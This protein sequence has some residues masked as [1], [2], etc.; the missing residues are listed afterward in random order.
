M[1]LCFEAVCIH[2][3]IGQ[4]VNCLSI[5]E[6]HHVR[7]KCNHKHLHCQLSEPCDREFKNSCSK[8]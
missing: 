5:V 1:H 4:L 6:T 8:V 2:L 7:Y 3:T